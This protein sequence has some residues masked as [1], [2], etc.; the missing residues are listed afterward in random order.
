MVYMPTQP[1]MQLITSCLYPSDRGNI[2]AAD[3][4]AQVGL[5]AGADDVDVAMEDGSGQ[6]SDTIP[7]PQP[8]TDLRRPAPLAQMFE[9]EFCRRHGLPKEDLLSIAVDLGGKGGALAAIEKARKVMLLGDRTGNVREWEEL[10]VR[11]ALLV[12]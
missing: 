8:Y 2:N 3:A 10:P 7:R 1:V 6:S 12:W 4:A 9:A 5:G 11:L